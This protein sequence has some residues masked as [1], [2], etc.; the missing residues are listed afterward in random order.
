M[1]LNTAAAD[2]EFPCP[3]VFTVESAQLLGPSSWCT[4]SGTR[5]VMA[6]GASTLAACL[7]MGTDAL[8]ECAC[9]SSS[10]C[11]NTNLFFCSADPTATLMPDDTLELRAGQK[12]LLDKLTNAAFMGNVT[13]GTCKDCSSP[14]AVV[15]TCHVI[16][17]CAIPCV[18][19]VAHRTT[20]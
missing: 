15:S 5:L 13:A 1:S 4:A 20:P 16:A 14:T 19:L 9:T 17:V 6:L 3:A 10:Y 11:S 12:L 2:A 18:D 8:R 7:R